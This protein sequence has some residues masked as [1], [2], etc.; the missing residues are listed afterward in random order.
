MGKCPDI[1]QRLIERFDQQADQV[2]TPD[3]NEAQLRIDF[4]N[5]MF[6]EL[7]WDMDN[8]QGFA[9]QYREVVHEDRV[10][11]GGQT[12]APDYS[13]RV[14]G[15]RKF[16]LEA[17]KPHVDI[18]GFWEPSYQLRR[19]GWSAKL[20]ASL[21]TNFAGLAIY[22]CRI[23][24]KQME[25]PSV[26]RREYITY[27]QYPEKWDFIE[28]TFSKRAILQGEFDRY[29]QTSKGRGAQEFDDAFLEE[30]EE[31]RKKLA[32]NLALRNEQL[33]ERSL[34][35]AVQRIIDRIIFLRICEDRGIEHT[36]QLRALLNGDKVYARLFDLFRNA[37]V[38]YNSG[39]FHFKPEKDRGESP[40]ELTE[41]LE[42]DD[43]TLKLILKRLYYPES[44]Y[45][46]TV[47]SADILGSV[48]ERFLGK[49]IRRAGNHQAKVEEKPEVRKAGGVYYTPK[50]I[51]DYIVQNTVGRLLSPS[52]PSPCTQGEGWGEG[53]SPT[54][55]INTKNG[56][57]D[58]TDNPDNPDNTNS[59]NA[60]SH[61]GL[62]GP[63]VVNNSLT[64][65][66]AA[67]LKIL[68]PACGSGSFLLGAYQ[69][70][71][72]WHLKWYVAD[73]PEKWSRGKTATLRPGPA[74][75]PDDWRL[76]IKERK[77]ILLDNIHGV[78]IDF[79]AVEVTKLSLLLRVLEGETAESLGGLWNLYRERALP[80]LGNNVKCGNSLVGADIYDTD[81][82]KNLSPDARRAVNAFD[83]KEEF[84]KVI[85]RGG[86]DA[87]IGNPPYGAELDEFQGTH[88]RN[89]TATKSTDTAALFVEKAINL[90]DKRGVFGLIIPKPFVYASNWE[91]TRDLVLPHLESLADVSKVWAEVKLEQCIIVGSIGSGS[92][93]YACL[94]RAGVSINDLGRIV[95]TTRQDYGFILN[96]VTPGELK[97]AEKI[98]TSCT[99][100]SSVSSNHRG[101]MLQSLIGQRGDL[102]ALGGKQI[103]RWQIAIDETKR[104][105]RT[106]L[107]DTKATI[108]PQSVLVQN[109]VA[110]IQNPVDHI[111]IIATVAGPEREQCLILDTV[112][113]LQC[114]DDT[115]ANYVCALLNSKLVNWYAYRFMFARAI[116]T[117]H[118]DAVTTQ[119]L[120]VPKVKA[121][122]SAVHRIVDLAAALLNLHR[123][124]ETKIS[125]QELTLR[126]RDVTAAVRKIDQLVY[127]L[128]GL[129][130]EEIRIVEEA[131]E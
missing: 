130:A 83:W 54:P 34:N 10:K 60:I 87:V 119:K 68:D 21:L 22:D 79:Q 105:S 28:G 23:A 116:R 84:S 73:G 63:S 29:C 125:P 115:H 94:N 72:D 55:E 78:D 109:I 45:E 19:Y 82:G 81:A 85:K 91:E 2:R 110:H 16:F 67:K 14:G 50:Y 7:G 90:L 27:Q 128:Y 74:G 108:G 77:R 65:T 43:A 88:L 92:A 41:T 62:S 102:F 48:Y 71:L 111:K 44:P 114:N 35:F 89:H 123:Q 69:Y 46:F 101:A 118:F 107:T 38:R 57:T 117:M 53:S 113:Q 3:Y 86:F 80:D 120:P 76:T 15:T 106:L 25:L 127:E 52:S 32:G 30:I 112:N 131:T 1:I 126:D 104:I 17:K 31:W 40:D 129:S 12:K 6:A 13:F 59:L 93:D 11:V 96:G 36:G 8:R 97:L 20:P 33:D 61:P 66:Q 51:V 100:L 98:R 4:V 70:L 75:P 49:V 56:T 124:H 5:P 24:P 42:V 47:V 37:D 99:S 26:A 95:K 58:N 121:N 103:Q 64:P 18:K 122:S 39:L 9:E